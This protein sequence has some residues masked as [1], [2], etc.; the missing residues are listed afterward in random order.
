MTSHNPFKGPPPAE[1]PLPRAPLVR[2]IAQIRFPKV[3][4]IGSGPAVAPFQE[5]IRAAYPTLQEDKIQNVQVNLGG[6][7]EVRVEPLWRFMDKSGAWRVS[8]SSEFLAIETKSYTSRSDFIARFTEVVQALATTLDPKIAIRIG[9]RYV[10]R[11]VAPEYDRLSDLI[12]RPV[13][14]L[15]SYN[16]FLATQRVLLTEGVFGADEGECRMRF[17]FLPANTI[18]EPEIMDAVDR[19]AWICDV[20]TSADVQMTFDAGDIKTLA[21]ALAERCYSVFRA[22]VTDEFLRAYGGTP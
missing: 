4:A 15:A 16:A 1:V 2:V 21:I 7:T 13:L 11:A 3:L 17:G 5:R 20:D 19:P 22:L 18:H 12:E 6:Q 9:V 14:G 8:L 10:S